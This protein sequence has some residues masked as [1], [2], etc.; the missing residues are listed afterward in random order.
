MPLQIHYV[1]RFEEVVAATVEFLSRDVDL[2]A[3]QRIVV[4]TAGAKAW[5]CGEL[6]RRLGASAG[7]AADGIIANVEIGFPGSITAL[8]QPGL[9]GADGWSLD[10]LTFAV[11][12]VITSRSDLGLPAT[13][14]A[15]PLL[16]AR[17]LATLFD[18][19]HVRRPGM[20]LRWE[21]GDPVVSPTA[22]DVL[23]DGER[24]TPVLEEGD[25]WQF[26]VW[27][28]VREL[29]GTPSPPARMSLAHRPSVEPL[30][31]AGLQS[32]SWHQLQCLQQL[33]ATCD[34]RVL[35]VHP[36]PGL[37]ARWERSLPEPR[38]DAPPL[39]TR[40]DPDPEF[41]EGVDQL[42]PVWLAGAREMQHLLASQGISA[43]SL[44]AAAARPGPD[45]LLD[46]MRSTVAAGGA[47]AAR[48]HDPCDRSLAIHRCHS[49][50]RQAEV[51]HD[52][53]LQAF[54][55]ID[56]LQPHDVLIVSPCI[57][58]A[59]P[60]LEAVFQRR[61]SGR[62][63]LGESVAVKLPLV[64]ADRGIREANEAVDLFVD[65]LALPGSRC[66]VD[67][68]LAVAGHPLV[69]VHF[70]VDDDTEALWADLIDR[71]QV[72][73]GLDGGHRTR[74]GLELATSPELHTWKLGLEA[75]LLGATLPDSAPR[76]EL[77]GVVPLV[78]LDPADIPA[79]AGLVRIFDV[80][81]SLEAATAS[82]R[83][84]SEWCDAIEAALVG[85]CG[86]ECRELSDP[87]AQVRRLREAA[88]GSAAEA[89]PVPFDDV[90][91]LL[92]SWCEEQPGRQP[93]RTGAIT[94]TSMVPLRG[95]P[96]RV[97][98]V[99]GYD[100]GAVGV[101]ESEGDDLVGRQQLIGDVDPRTDERRALLDCLLAA[102]DRL[103]IM[104]NGRSVKNNQPL[105]LVTPLAELV[106]FAVRHGARRGAIDEPSAIEIG[107]PRHHLGLKNF[108][109]GGVQ[110]GVIWSHDAH[111]AEA[112]RVVGFED[113]GRDLSVAEAAACAGRPSGAIP[114]Q[115]PAEKPVIELQVL[116]RMVVDPLRLY[117]EETLGIST[118]REN[119]QATPA[120]F[121]LTLENYQIRALT[122]DLL[123]GLVAGSGAEQAWIE[124][125]RQSGRLP[126]GPHG[127][128]QLDEIVGLAR[129]LRD[130]AVRKGLPL[131]GTVS[132]EV[133][134]DLQAARVVGFLSGVHEASQQMV[135]VTTGKADSKS[136]ARPL[137]VAALQLV[138]ARAAGLD[139]TRVAVLSRHSTWHPGA[140][141]T[142]GRPV[143]PCQ[144]RTICLDPA[145][146]PA[147][148]LEE[149]CRLAREAVAAPCGLFGLAGVSAGDRE[150]AFGR[151]VSDKVWGTQESRYAKRP[152]AMVYGLN[153]TFRQVF[154]SRSREL[155]FLDAFNAI[156]T[157]ESRGTT[158]TLT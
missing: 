61:V 51:L 149:F 101:L 57:E 20:I 65:V 148:R 3:R 135:V 122:L 114:R 109:V 62:N 22:S 125:V 115:P 69:R 78:D 89:T 29:I 106:D 47:A 99:I 146:E 58:K 66:S 133:R 45:T 26:R 83:P 139:V 6:A 31:V 70:G 46:R 24:E 30:L 2:F 37:Q 77:G 17:R 4:P 64:V 105:P 34:V 42:L 158:Y 14:A 67:D 132:R 44:P 152:E 96:F 84:V 140:V 151:F 85:L 19:Y 126:F 36:S 71:A 134:V 59:A 75:M 138:A 154:A 13:A 21:Q 23:R 16:A 94:A 116:E 27:R 103:V 15:E 7:S 25:R 33:G 72:R 104:C 56:G 92:G 12:K 60:H 50:S 157:L 119:E 107:H 76:P 87:L 100:D 136:S 8:L 91:R 112:A 123:R 102:E 93:L 43:T 108:V 150:E 39:P 1:S 86:A 111:A 120:T 131:A 118:W 144:I 137:H 9:R 128:R 35:L 156:L 28:A 49:L 124:A 143:N 90:R 127:D 48:D 10:R 55:E 130:E 155:A 141:S 98:C 53:L 81:R 153:P 113:A 11:V 52:A 41:L 147:A 40:R 68:V 121:P 18:A 73:W 5:L 82:C 95:V 110:E 74:R 32:L 54:Q 88:A 80:L 117:L 97:V 63:A 145:V 129:G 38:P 79:I 142:A